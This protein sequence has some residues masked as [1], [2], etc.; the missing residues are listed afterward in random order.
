MNIWESSCFLV[1]ARQPMLRYRDVEELT[2]LSSRTIARLVNTNQFPRPVKIGR[3]C[4]WRPEDIAR[5]M[6]QQAGGMAFAGG[7]ASGQVV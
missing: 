1:P 6:G 2:R 3:S 7:T 4:R 5:F